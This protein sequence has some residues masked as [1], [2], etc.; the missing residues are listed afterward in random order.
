MNK[1]ATSADHMRPARSVL[2][3]QFTRGTERLLCQ[4]DRDLETGAYAV[5]LV[6]C[7]SLRR[8]SAGTFRAVKSAL[9]RHAVVVNQLRSAGWTI[10][11]YTR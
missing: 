2:Q 7:N 10:A 5:G 8:A 3:W 4:I 9:R 1:Y 6:A 11:A